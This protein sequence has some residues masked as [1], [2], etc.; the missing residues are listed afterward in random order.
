MKLKI[1][2]EDAYHICDKSQ[3]KEACLWEKLKLKLHLLYCRA[4]RK[5]SVRNQKLSK[6]VERSNIRTV[7]RANKEQLREQLRKE[8]DK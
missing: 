3:Y 2:C 6:L 7:P 4:C 8:L 5:Y 1:P